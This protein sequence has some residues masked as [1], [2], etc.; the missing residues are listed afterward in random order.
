LSQ[1]VPTVFDNYSMNVM[2]RSGVPTN[3]AFWDTA[4]QEDYDRLR[5]LSYPQT[6][7]FLVCFAVNNQ[8]SLDEVN[9]KWVPEIRHHCPSAHIVLVG[10]KSDLRS[11]G[12]AGMMVDPAVAQAC[13][14]A[15]D[16]Q[17]PYHET[18]ALQQHG[19]G[20]ELSEV[21]IQA[22]A[23]TGRESRAA[24]RSGCRLS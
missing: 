9:S 24:G 17:Q 2:S 6:D 22:A 15:L 16:L 5:P 18:S 1:Y 20:R 19:I 3:I 11:S 13:A 4:G 21:I 7:V 12:A 10:T 14:T 23:L 8:S